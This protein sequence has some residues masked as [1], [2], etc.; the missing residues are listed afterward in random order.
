M[1]VY[2]ALHSSVRMCPHC[3][4][5]IW[6]PGILV[7][8]AFAHVSHLRWTS[9]Q[10]GEGTNSSLTFTYV[11]SRSAPPGYCFLLCVHPPLPSSV[12]HLCYQPLQRCFPN[13][14]SSWAP[15]TVFAVLLGWLS[16]GRA[17]SLPHP[18]ASNDLRAEMADPC[19]WQTRQPGRDWAS[20]HLA[21]MSTN[22]TLLCSQSLRK[23]PSV[24]VCVLSLRMSW[25]GSE[26]G[27]PKWGCDL[28]TSPAQHISP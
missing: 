14:L 22:P 23:G 28:S 25:K 12:S 10:G 13:A 7:P 1:H 3:Q 20:C 15:L 11:S 4:P 17:F 26:T 6:T 18:S 9:S 21:H 16:R 5:G 19:D 24:R 27:R 8:T 2:L